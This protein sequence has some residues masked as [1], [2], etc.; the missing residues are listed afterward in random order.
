MQRFTTQIR[1]RYYEMDALGH[2]NNSVYQNYLEQVAVEHAEQM[3]FTVDRYRQM[4]GIF[5]LRRIQ[6]EYLLP[7]VAGD[8]L[9]I[10]TW[11][12]KMR[13]PRAI[14]RYEIYRQ[15]EGNPLLTAEALWVWVNSKNMRPQAIPR[16]VLTEF[17]QLNQVAAT[18]ST[19]PQTPS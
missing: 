5:V 3:G 13:G 15:G 10:T 7:A 4:G 11:V 1:V 6:I 14:R 12:E 8:L 9:N 19:D 16:E 17:E 18:S 2:V